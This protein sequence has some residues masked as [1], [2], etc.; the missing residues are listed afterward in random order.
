MGVKF[1]LLDELV[2]LT[3]EEYF[4]I[5]RNSQNSYYGL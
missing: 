2:S 1:S 3:G 4:P 5:I